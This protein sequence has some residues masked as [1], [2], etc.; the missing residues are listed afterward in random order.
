MRMEIRFIQQ[1]DPVWNELMQY[2]HDCSWSAGPWLAKDMAENKFNDWERVLVATE[3]NAIA[4]Y[5]T[6]AMT[7]CIPEVS[8]HPYIG[9]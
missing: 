1:S 7:D 5:C 4:G 8:Y 6:F 9:Y 3:G 2:A